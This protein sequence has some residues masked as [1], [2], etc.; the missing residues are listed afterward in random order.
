MMQFD[1][2]QFQLNIIVN[3][4][5]TLLRPN[6]QNIKHL[7]NDRILVHFQAL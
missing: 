3:N 1:Y 6:A 4:L 2:F 7:I 5:T